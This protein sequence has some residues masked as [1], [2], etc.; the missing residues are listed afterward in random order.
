[1][2]GLSIWLGSLCLLLGCSKESM[3]TDRYFP[4]QSGLRWT[5]RVTTEPVGIRKNERFEVH[6]SDPELVDGVLHAVRV[7]DQ[8]TRYYV[9]DTDDGI[10]R[11]AKRTLVE[12]YP[13]PDRP[14]RWILKRPFQPGNTW[15][16]ET[17]PY[18]LRRLQPYEESLAK[19]INF[20]MAY[21]ISAL[22]DT[23][24]VSAGRFENCIRVDGDAQLTVYA[25][26]RTGYQ[27][28]QINT[29]EW[30]APGVGLVKLVREEPLRSDVFAG[31]RV[32]FELERFER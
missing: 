11:A 13:Q 3:D 20:K 7:T 16:N 17:H 12:L 30:Y 1:M 29:T 27:D 14:L 31:G 2:K 21:Q 18:V 25:D 5:Y 10:F 32:E 9:R 22:A 6:N 19:G 26:G 28:I 8:G 15:S 4:L 24:D 23:V